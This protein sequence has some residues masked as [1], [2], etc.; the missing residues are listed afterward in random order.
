M[1]HSVYIYIYLSVVKCPA[2][3]YED[4]NMTDLSNLNFY[5][6]SMSM[7]LDWWSPPDR[8]GRGNLCLKTEN[9]N[10]HGWRVVHNSHWSSTYESRCR[11]PPLCP[12]ILTLKERRDNF[13]WWQRFFG[14]CDAEGEGEGGVATPTPRVCLHIIA[15]R[16]RYREWQDQC[17]CVVV[18]QDYCQD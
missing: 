4:V 11:A 1:K 7:I 5:Q 14:I 18:S 15:S 10:H 13:C 17:C 16:R 9:I 8:L 2:V 6:P 3:K 12:A